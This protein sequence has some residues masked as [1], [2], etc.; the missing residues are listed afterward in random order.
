MND[1]VLTTDQMAADAPFGSALARGVGILRCFSGHRQQ[2][3]RKELVELTGL[4]KATVSRL[5]QTLCELGLLRQ[6]PRDGSFVLGADLLTLVP[7]IL[8][9]MPMR[10]VARAAMQELADHAPMQVTIAA[11]TGA[12]L[13]FVEICQGHGCTVHRPEI[14]TRLS[15]T[16]TASGRVYLLAERPPARDR[17]LRL[18]ARQDKA[19]SAWLLG[20]LAEARQHLAE[21]GF[22]YNIGDMHPDI[23]GVA[24][25]VRA[26]VDGQILVFTCTVATFQATSEQLLSDIGPRLSALVRGVAATLPEQAAIIDWSAEAAPSGPTETSMTAAE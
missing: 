17:V 9:R 18:L 14:G 8:A 21:R 5:T 4:P 12:D 20:K 13:V 6:L 1:N 23:M 7:A 15:L 3:S 25:P 2:L 11:G 19:R 22:A 10:Q 16:R 26:A 24:I